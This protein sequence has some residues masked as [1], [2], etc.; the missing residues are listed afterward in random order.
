MEYQRV[1]TTDVRLSKIGFRCGSKG[2]NNSNICNEKSQIETIQKALDLG[3]N[4]FDTADIYC[5]GQAEKILSKGL[6]SHRK[7][8]FI[9]TKVGLR[10]ENK[11]YTTNLSKEYIKEA[12]EQSLRRLKTDVIDFY[13]AH[14]PDTNTPLS[15]TFAAFNECVEEGKVRFIGISNFSL[16]LLKQCSKYSLLASHMIPLNFFKRE[17]EIQ[18][19]PH[20]YRSNIAVLASNPLALG[21]LR[22]NYNINTKFDKEFLE[23]NPMLKGATFR[24]N[25]VIVE[26]LKSF[27]SNHNK[28]INELAIAWV[29][30]HTAVTSTTCSASTPEEITEQVNAINWKLS[31]EELAQIELLYNFG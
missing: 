17:S 14:W 25:L 22:G 18:V 29:L 9:S 3:I 8:V 24:R 16:D 20:C 12:I 4:F 7:K 28:S 19:M 11:R 31:Q 21:L 15:E 1:G 30:A 6:G 26:R 23:N 2:F 13:Q 5:N 27:C 10:Y